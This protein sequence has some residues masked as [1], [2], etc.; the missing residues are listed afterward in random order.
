MRRKVFTD[1]T[2]FYR[3]GLEMLFADQRQ[4]KLSIP[5]QNK[6]GKPTTVASLIDHLCQDVMKDSRKELFVLEDRMY[7]FTSSK[8]LQNDLSLPHSSRDGFMMAS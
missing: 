5:A 8:P 7:V 1:R 4:H 6:Q 2:P 3:G